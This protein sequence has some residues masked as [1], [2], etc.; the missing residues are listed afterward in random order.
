MLIFHG[1]SCKDILVLSLNGNEIFLS[2]LWSDSMNVP[3]SP[4]LNLLKGFD[5]CTV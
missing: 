5:I 4:C 2:T 1:N 3:N